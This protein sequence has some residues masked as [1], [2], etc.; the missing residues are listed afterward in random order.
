MDLMSLVMSVPKWGWGGQ[1][2]RCGPTLY[3][4]VQD[5]SAVQLAKKI[6]GTKDR[7][8]VCR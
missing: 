6:T 3:N 7:V 5:S 8:L 2:L 4:Q 1:V